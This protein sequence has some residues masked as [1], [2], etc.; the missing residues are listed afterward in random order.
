MELID[1]KERIENAVK[2]IL[3]AIGENPNREGLKE[4]PK[5]VAKMLL[6]ELTVGYN[7]NPNDLLT[8]FDADNYDEFVIIKDISFYSMCEH[9]MLPIIGKAHIA[10]LPDKKVI[11]ASKLARLVELHARR[12]QIQERMTVDIAKDLEKIL[13][14]KAVA[15]I[16]EAEHLCMKMRGIKNSGSKM[17]TDYFS[18]YLRNNNSLRA[19][20]LNNLK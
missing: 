4:T 3:I 7:Q 5:R 1:N 15:V 10:Y 13:K 19:E 8:V 6:N 14:P 18:E 2:E 9:H 16:I 17:V 20:L 12:L 11:G